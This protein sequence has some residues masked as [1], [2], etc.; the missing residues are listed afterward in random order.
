VGHCMRGK[1]RGRRGEVPV[2]SLILFPL[3]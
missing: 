2:K 3:V 1:R